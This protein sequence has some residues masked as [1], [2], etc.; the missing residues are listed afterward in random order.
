MTI[1]EIIQEIMKHADKYAVESY[2]MI[3]TNKTIPVRKNNKKRIQKKWIKKYGMMPE[4]ERKK[5]KK[6]D[7]T[8]KLI[9]DFCI[10]NNYP[11]PSDLCETI[12]FI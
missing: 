6:I 3:P 1:N 4:Y 12:E 10:E 5:C 9:I 8:P 2:E 11:L 7:V